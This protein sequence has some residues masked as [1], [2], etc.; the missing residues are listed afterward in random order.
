MHIAKVD[1][2]VARLPK[3][4]EALLGIAE[5]RLR[6]PEWHERPGLDVPRARGARYRKRLFAHGYGFDRTIGIGIEAPET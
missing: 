5:G 2:Q 1:R 3:G 6:R 4:S